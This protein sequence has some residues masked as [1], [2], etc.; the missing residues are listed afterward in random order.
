MKKSVFAIALASLLGLSV[1]AQAATIT[2]TAD[3]ALTKTNWLNSLVLGKFDTNLGQLTS[4]DFS[5]TGLTQGLGRTENLSPIASNATLTLSSTF[6]LS[7]AGNN[8]LTVTNPVFAQTFALGSFDGTIDFGGR[9]GGST[10]TIVHSTT[11]AAH[12]TTASDFAAFS[13]AGGGFINLDLAAV[14]A[15]RAT[16]AG[17]L[18]S[19][20]TTK[21]S[22]HV[23]V[24]YNYAPVPEPETYAMML[25]GLGLLTAMR[26]RKNAN[27]LG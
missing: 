10:G 9:S 24:T 1:S 23:E 5:V 18:T 13:A 12:D 8:L 27:K 11:S 7:R 20:F 26:R 14:G 4:I 16:G 25:A 19:A 6:T 2:F 17:N 15:S 22:G 3:Q 21:S